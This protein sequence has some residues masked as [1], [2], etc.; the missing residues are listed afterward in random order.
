MSNNSN[1]IE[2]KLCRRPS[3]EEE[4]TTSKAEVNYLKNRST[5]VFIVVFW[6]LQII[7]KRSG[8]RERERWRTEVK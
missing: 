2:N 7:R 8:E 3:I 5:G 1:K 4:K 6:F